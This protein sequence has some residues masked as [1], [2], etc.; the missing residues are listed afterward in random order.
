MSPEYLVNGEGFELAKTLFENKMLGFLAVDESHCISVWGH[1][2]RNSYLKLKIFR[3]KFPKIPILALTA[4]ATRQVVEEIALLLNLKEP[5]LIKAK[6][7]RPNLYL[8]CIKVD[9]LYEKDDGEE[10]I[11]KDIVNNNLKP[12]LNKY[13]DG[14]KIIIYMNSR[15]NCQDMTD[16]IKNMG[17]KLNVIMLDYLKE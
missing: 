17:F 2:F 16:V 11:S 10:I 12:Y 9:K 6:F 4:T 7:D 14:S 13:N 3:E 1:D 8:K 5:K 15:K